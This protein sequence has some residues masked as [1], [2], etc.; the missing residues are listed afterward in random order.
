MA[1]AKSKKSITPVVVGKVKVV[2]ETAVLFII[3]DVEYSVL[4]KPRPNVGLK[5]LRLSANEGQEKAIDYLMTTML[6][7]E[8]WTALTDCET[9][10]ED[11]FTQI[12]EIVQ[13]MALGSTEGAVKN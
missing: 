9:L 10:T 1:A 2:E 11:E 6:G 12:M 7:V 13:G 4:T 3:D 8:G 5:Y